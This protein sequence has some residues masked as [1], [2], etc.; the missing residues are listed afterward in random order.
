MD[1]QLSQDTLF[2][3]EQ[4][5]VGGYYSVRGFR[6]NYIAG[7][8]GYYFR[9]KANINL[10]Q[11]L[12]PFLKKEKKS[13][14]EN[15]ISNFFDK[16]LHHLYK[17]SMEPFYDYGYVQ[18]KYSESGEINSGRLSGAGLKTI[19]SSKY[20]DASMTYS[21]SLNKSSLITSEDKEN[22]MLYFE[23]SVKCC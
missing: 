12:I 1:S 9:N 13:K 7:D 15:K 11:L 23:I 6:E 14:S 4:F 16:N 3:S 20:F 10:G 2:G 5:S 22:K 21:W 8:S 18:N 17:F 19:F